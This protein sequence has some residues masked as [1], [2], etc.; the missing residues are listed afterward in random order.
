MGY[1]I[2]I[3]NI[4]G[5]GKTNSAPTIA[6]AIYKGNKKVY[7]ITKGSKIVFDA[8]ETTF[9]CSAFQVPASGG[10]VEDFAKVYSYGTDYNGE[11]HD[12]AYT[13]SQVVIPSNSGTTMITGTITVT[14][15]ATKETITVGYA[16]SAS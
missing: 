3:N 1:Y 13:F 10:N 14:Q 12:M 16:Q 11:K 15:T 2:L 9:Q 8:W 4:Y 5:R 6:K 7:R